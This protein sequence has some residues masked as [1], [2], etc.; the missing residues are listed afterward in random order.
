MWTINIDGTNQ[1]RL[2]FTPQNPPN[3]PTWSIHPS[4][5]PDGERIVY[6]STF[7]GSSQIWMMNADGTYRRQLT[8]TADPLSSDNPVWSP[9]GS[10]ILFD[11]NRAA[12][13][14]AG[15]ASLVH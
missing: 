9:D 10:R 15:S 5:S 11:T 13:P 4:W 6:A 1:T 7:S 12:P 14:Q 3:V 2:T 8:E